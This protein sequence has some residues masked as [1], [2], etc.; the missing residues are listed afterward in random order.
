MNPGPLGHSLRPPVQQIFKG[1]L[2]PRQLD[3]C[4]RS[5][6][7]GGHRDPRK[8]ETSGTAAEIFHDPVVHRR[9]PDS[10]GRRSGP[11]LEPE[12]FAG[13]RPRQP[14]LQLQRGQGVSRRQRHKNRRRPGGPGSDPGS[15]T[16]PAT[17]AETET[18]A[19]EEGQVPPSGR[20]QEVRGKLFGRSPRFRL[21]SRLEVGQAVGPELPPLHPEAHQHRP[22]QEDQRD[23]LH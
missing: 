2:L 8:V 13:R 6:D 11:G 20:L 4:V 9:S 18:G 7:E 19:A 17:E 15:G 3:R 1:A 21:G 10:G 22:R 12:V 23:L 16:E 14:H 5:D